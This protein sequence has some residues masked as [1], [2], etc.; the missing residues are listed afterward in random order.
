MHG[1]GFPAPLLLYLGATKDLAVRHPKEKL[2]LSRTAGGFRSTETAYS[3]LSSPGWVC[4]SAAPEAGICGAL[5]SSS[6]K[7]CQ[8]SAMWVINALA[9]S[10]FSLAAAAEHSAAFV[11]GSGRVLS[12]Q[13]RLFLCQRRSTEVHP[14]MGRAVAYN[15]F[16][17]T[18][19][20]RE[21]RRWLSRSI[22][23]NR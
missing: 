15:S 16:I 3:F 11:Q 4:C 7:C 8:V 13:L 19:Q 18:V 10:S 9:C 12:C 20:L 6:A 23:S 17:Q 22:P 21:M 2:R 14:R 1:A 5:S